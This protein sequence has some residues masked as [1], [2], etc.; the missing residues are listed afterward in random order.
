MTSPSGRL[1]RSTAGLSPGVTKKVRRYLARPNAEA[2]LVDQ[3]AEWDPRRWESALPGF[4]DRL[5]AIKGFRSAAASR[6]GWLV[7]TRGEMLSLS[8]H[9]DAVLLFLA[10]MIWGYGRGG[11]QFHVQEALGLRRPSGKSEPLSSAQALA[12]IEELRDVARRDALEAFRV[13]ARPD[14]ELHL[15]GTGVTFAT[16]FIYSAGFDAA[17]RDGR[18]PP[19]ILDSYVARA[20]GIPASATPRAYERYLALAHSIR[21]ERPD[22]VELALLEAGFQM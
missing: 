16:K 15:P 21:P 6:P 12:R 13:S 1:I 20:L 18:I 19:L 3:A 4:G 10:T 11:R 2:E 14:A 8:D 5:D 7:I 17:L 9:P 22:L